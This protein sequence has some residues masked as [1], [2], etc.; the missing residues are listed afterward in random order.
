[1]AQLGPPRKGSHLI[2]FVKRLNDLR[3]RYP[4][5]RRDRF[6]TGEYIEELGVK[7]VTWI[8]ANGI[9][10]EDK[11]WGDSGMRCFGML[12]DGRAQKSGIRK[13]GEEVTLL[14]II[15]GHTDVVEFALPKCAGGRAWSLLI[16]TNF[17]DLCESGV[18]EFGGKY[19]V[20]SRSVLLFAL[21]S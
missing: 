4:I 2:D 10:M 9:E 21:G 12:L 20:T 17:E 11:Q 18:F 6:L 8:N 16:D 3:H 15:N 19:D 5:L 13:L 14:M 1:L 7:D